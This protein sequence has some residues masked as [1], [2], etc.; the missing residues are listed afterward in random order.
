MASIKKRGKSWQVRVFYTDKNGNRKSLNKLGFRTKQEA[1]DFGRQKEIELKSGTSILDPKIPFSKYF[2]DWYMTY[3][4][5]SL[6]PITLSRYKATEKLIANFFG[7]K[8][9]MSIKRAEYQKFITEYGQKHAPAT[10]REKNTIIKRCVQNAIYDDVIKKDFTFNITLVSNKERE[11]HVDYMNISE[12]RKLTKYLLK[13][14]DYHYGSNYMILTAIFTGARLGELMALTWQDINF[15]FKTI[16]INKAWNYY[17]GGKFKSTKTEGSNRTIPINQLLVDVLKDLKK[18]K[19][20]SKKEQVFMTQFGTVPTSNAVNKTLR[21]DMKKLNINRK[22]FHFHSLRHSH[23]AYLL[24]LGIDIYAI[25]K[26]LGHNDITT[27][28]RTYAYL[29]DEY[30][31]ENDQRITAGLDKLMDEPKNELKKSSKII[32]K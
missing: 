27:T 21:D 16:R 7:D 30:K 28:T 26:R 10:V 18:A 17:E 25:A 23:V 24:S 8:P 5:D 13:H 31:H 14:L 9:M 1:I 3:K 4:A 19:H 12:L 11:M 6:M 22:N 32:N 29:I 15:N 2:R 20:P